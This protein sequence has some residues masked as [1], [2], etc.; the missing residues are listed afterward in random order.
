MSNRSSGKIKFNCGFDHSLTEPCGG[1]ELEVILHNT[2]DTV[3]I[4][5]D[6]ESWCLSDGGFCALETAIERLKAK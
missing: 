5:I 4:I 2:S 3:S 6:N 1:H